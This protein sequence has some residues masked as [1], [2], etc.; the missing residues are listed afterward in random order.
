MNTFSDLKGTWITFE[1]SGNF[2]RIFF[3]VAF[4]FDALA[5]PFVDHTD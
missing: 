3:R 5:V 1:C 2:Y 4:G